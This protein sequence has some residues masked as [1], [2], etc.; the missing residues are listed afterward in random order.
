MKYAWLV[1]LALGGSCDNVSSPSVASMPWMRGFNAV[2]VGDIP[3]QAA[4]QRM[5]D[6]RHVDAEDAHDV[7]ELRADIVGDSSLETVLVSYRLGVMVVDAAGRAVATAP[8]FEFSG[9][10]DDLVSVAIG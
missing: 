5:A 2:V 9:S 4:A 10:A 6:L 3:T 1:L 8:G 7:I